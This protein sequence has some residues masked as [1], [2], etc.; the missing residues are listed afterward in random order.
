M[1]FCYDSNRI[2][3]NKTAKLRLFLFLIFVF[4]NFAVVFFPIPLLKRFLY[5][6]EIFHECDIKHSL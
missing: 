2:E 5:I 3:K 4:R 6:F 1:L